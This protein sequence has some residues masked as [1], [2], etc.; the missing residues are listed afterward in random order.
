MKDLSLGR[1]NALR[2]PLGLHVVL[3]P[4]RDTGLHRCDQLGRAID[5]AAAAHE[6]VE[7]QS[8]PAG[9]P[10]FNVL[11][12]PLYDLRADLRLLAAASLCR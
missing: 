12:L 3:L 8:F 11:T 4:A 1:Q 10:A 6:L 9:R 7:C 2:H 5:L